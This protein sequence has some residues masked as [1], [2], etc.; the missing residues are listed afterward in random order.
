MNPYVHKFSVLLNGGSSVVADRGLTLPQ[1]LE[2][3]DESTELLGARETITSNLQS[4]VGLS[5]D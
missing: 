3:L 2:H 4:K 5:L 1:R